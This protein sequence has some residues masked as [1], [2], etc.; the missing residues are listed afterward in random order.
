MTKCLG[1]KGRPPIIISA[2][3][4]E[5]KLVL[6]RV[7]LGLNED[8]GIKANEIILLTPRSTEN[9]QWSEGERIAKFVLT[10]NL[11]S[12]LPTS[13]RVCTIQSF[14]G[15]ECPVVILTEMDKAWQDEIIYVGLSR[16]CNQVYVIGELPE[17]KGMNTKD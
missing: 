9:S 6:T 11:E 2:S 12:T 3:N 15:L 13:I 16:A 5:A 4:Y 7:L 10:W 8:K 14:K 1:P 17:P